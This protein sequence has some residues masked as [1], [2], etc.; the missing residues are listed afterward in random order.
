MAAGG[1]GGSTSTGGGGIIN[2]TLQETPTWALAT[3]CFVFIF[4][5]IFIEYLIHLAGHV[6]TVS[7]CNI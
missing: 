2:R 1:G 5:G 4:L 6:S 7:N 3:V